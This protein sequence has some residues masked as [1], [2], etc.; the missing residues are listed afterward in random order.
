[1]RKTISRHITEKRKIKVYLLIIAPEPIED[2]R[3]SNSAYS[4]SLKFSII[5]SL[6]RK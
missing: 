5:Y 3:Q 1:M 6:E 2:K 4:Q